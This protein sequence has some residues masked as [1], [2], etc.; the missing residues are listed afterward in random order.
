MSEKQD[1]GLEEVEDFVESETEQAEKKNVESKLDSIRSFDTESV[2][3]VM[4]GP[5]TISLVPS[6]MEAKF[7]KTDSNDSIG[8]GVPKGMEY[9][10]DKIVGAVNEVA[11]L[12]KEL[13]DTKAEL[14]RVKSEH[15]EPKE[16]EEKPDDEEKDPPED[17]EPEDEEKAE[18]EEKDKEE[19]AKKEKE[20][21]EVKQP[22]GSK[23]E[24]EHNEPGMDDLMKG[25][26]A[27]KEQKIL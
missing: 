7:V 18:S 19:E 12:E 16:D 25:L 11:R 21:A 5:K 9:D 26:K 24:A 2:S 22:E 20:E 3:H 8:L 14:E 13:A 17:E 6:G 4:I 27:A 1:V 10:L 23:K 15:A